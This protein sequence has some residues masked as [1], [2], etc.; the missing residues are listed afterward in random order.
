[1]FKVISNASPLIGLYKINLL[2]ILKDLWQEVIIPEAVYKE[3]VVEGA[4][5]A[6]AKSI[7]NLCKQWL[8]KQ[9][10]KNKNEVE[11]L[12]T[13]LDEGEAEVI[14]LAQEINASLVLID[15]KEPRLFAKK[16]NLNVLGTIGIII[17]AYKKKLIKNPDKKII[18]LKLKLIDVSCFNLFEFE[19]L[20]S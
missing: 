15:N 17:L 5:K 9:K 19:I 10:V 1:M 18:Q 6:G 20:L 7:E 12:K 2:N 14:A 13:I 11:A 4:A 8:K 3:I 16:L